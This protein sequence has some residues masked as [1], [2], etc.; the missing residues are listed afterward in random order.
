M[1]QLVELQLFELQMFKF[2]IVISLSCLKWF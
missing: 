2:F 1:S